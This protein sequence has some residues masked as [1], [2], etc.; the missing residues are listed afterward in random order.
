MVKTKKSA[1]PGVNIT[2][3][4]D[5]IPKGCSTPDFERKPIT[6]TLQEGKNAIFRAVV[7]GDP[8]PEILWQR[9]TGKIDDHERYRVSCVPGTNEYTLQISNITANDADVYR[10]TA[11][12]EYGEA[13]CSAGLKIIQVG[14]KKKPKDIAVAPQTDLKKEIK[15]F[16]KA[17][18]K[19]TPTAAPKKEIDMEQ[20]WQLLL[21][22]DRKDYE[23]ICLKY[24]IVD[25]R[26]MLRRLQEMKEE[27]E[28]KQAEYV[29]SI[30]NLKHVKI[31]E[32]QAN[33]SI[34]LEMELKNP[35]SR[36]YLY[37]DGEMINFGLNDDNIKH[38]LRQVGKK[39]NFVINDLQPEDAGV[40]QIK[41]EDVDI[42]S[43][44]LEA[45]NIPIYFR[46]PLGDV[47]CH[48]QGN[49]VLQCT[50][51]DPCFNAVWLHK[52]NR[53]EPNE[54]YEIS[55]S[56][57]GLMH[58]LVIKNAQ[59]SDKG[60]YTIDIG[61]RT[62]SAWLEVESAKGK[63]KQLEGD[64]ND[65]VGLRKKQLEDDH[66][67]KLRQGEA[68]DNQDH[69]A[70]SNM[71]KIG[72]YGTGQDGSLG[73][74]GKMGQLS[75]AGAD[76]AS[77][78]N[79]QTG[80]YGKDSMRDGAAVTGRPGSAGGADGL[81]GR[82]SMTG[83]ASEQRG[84][85]G[86]GGLYSKD[87][88]SDGAGGAGGIGGIY[89]KE[90]MFDSGGGPGGAVGLG[91]IY[92][93]DGVHIRAGGAGI[94][95]KDGMPGGT[96][97]AGYGGSGEAGGLY[98]KD[99]MLGGTGSAGVP[100]GIGGLYDKRGKPFGSGTGPDSN[101]GA[102]SLYGT[103]G[104]LGVAGVAGLY[105]KGGMPVGAGSSVP[106]G[107]G[108]A[109]GFYGRD[110]IL[111]GAGGSGGA[112]GVGG[113]GGIPVGTG[114]GGAGASGVIGGPYGKDGMLGG[115]GGAGGLEGLCDKDGK[116]GTAGLGGNGRAGGLGGLYGKGGMVDSSDR[117]GGTGGIGELYDKDGLPVGA[118]G[119]A[120]I[121]D[122]NGMITGV[123]P[124]GDA[125]AGGAGGFYGKD[126][127]L[128]STG[129]AGGPGGIGGFYGK[130]GMAVGT[131][132]SGLGGGRAVG[133]LY[134]KDGS[135]IG[136][137]GPGALGG[138]GGPHGAGGEGGRY[139]KDGM[140]VGSGTGRPGN[141]VGAESLYGKDGMPLKGGISAL[142]GAGGTGV[143]YGKDGEMGSAGSLH[144]KDHVLGG[145]SGVAGHIGG[146]YGIDGSGGPVGSGG[147][148][149]K[150]GTLGGGSD[151]EKLAGLYGKD[152]MPYGT[153]TAEHYGSGGRGGL[154]GKSGMGDAGEHP[155]SG[156]LGRHYGKD[157]T[158]AGAGT[159]GV[160][161][162]YGQDG[163][164]VEIGT[165]G[166][167]GAGGKGG[168]YGKDGMP[169]GAGMV[170]GLHGQDGMPF[171][172]GTGGH[173]GAGSKSGLYGKDGMPAGAGFAAPGGIG[174]VGGLYGQDGMPVGIGTGGP[175]SAGVKGGY[176][177]KDGMPAGA[178]TGGVGGLYGQDGMPVG[179]G[180]GGHGGAGGVGGLYGK[181]GMP[182]GAGMVG[183]LHGQD[184]MPFGIGTGGLA[185]AGGKGGLYGKDGMPAGAGTGGVGGLYGQDGMPVG[186]GTSGLAGA[187]D[188][189]GLYGKDG[190][191][192][193]AGFAAPGGIGGV[194]GLY[195][196]DGLPVGIGTGGPDGAGV[197]GGY[198]GKDGMPAGAGTGGVGGLY[199]QD[200]MPVGIGT[201]GHGGAGGVGGLYGKDG[202]PA[203]AGTGGVGGLYGQ[204]G[205]PVGLGT[206]GLA[207]AGG[208]GGLHGQDGMPAGAGLAGPGGIGGVRGL[209]GQDGM[210]VGI[211]TSG[212]AGAGGK[213]GLYG[214]DG[215]PAGAGT[216][217]V[218]GLYGKDG[219]PAGAGP[220]GPGGVGGVAGLYGPDGIPVG[221]GGLA[222]AGGKGE[223][224]GQDG[225]P[226]GAGPAGPGGI[227]GVAGLYGPDGIPVGIGTAGLAGAG[228]KGGLYG[229]DG[230]P[231]G[232]GTGGVGGLYGQDGMPVGIG[233]GGLAGAGGKGGLYGKDGMLAGAG[234]A[235]P[236]GIGGVS[237]LYGPDGMPVG[238]GTTG[239]SGAVG[240]GSL[241]DKAGIQGGAGGSGGRGGGLCGQDG[242]PI[243]T[244][245][246]GFGTAGRGG[247]Y[248]QDG[249]PGVVGTQG[250]G[251]A[252]GLHGK[253][254]YL[255]SPG[256]PD[257]AGGVAALYGKDGVLG[258]AVGA[259]GAGGLYGKDGIL[260]G[261][262]GA[263]SAGGV[264][265]LHGKD[266]M[267]IVS[268][269]GGEG[270]LHG[271]S[272]LPGGEGR[273]G[274]GSIVDHGG[275]YGKDGRAD[276]IGA[277]G[278]GLSE[279]G[280]L[281]NLF[282]KEG[283]LGGIG[284]GLG[285]G[286][287]DGSL[288]EKMSGIPGEEFLA[289]GQSSG[290]YGAGY[291]PGD[292]RQKLS[293]LDASG[294]IS[295]DVSRSRDRKGR[296]LLEEDAREPHC[297]FTQGLFDIHAHKGKAAVLLC[298]LNNDQ[299][300]GN[301]FKDG[302]KITGSDGVS[303]EKEGPVHK[304]IIDEVQEKHAGKY[305]FEAEDIRTEA[306]IFVEDPPSIDSALLNKL[307]NEPI[308]VKAGK[309]TIVKIPFEGR[310]PIRATWLKDDGELLD[311][312][313]IS[314]DYSDDYTRLTISSTNRKDSGDYKVKLKNESGTTEATLKLIVI[315][316]PQPPTGP[317]VV[318]DSSTSGIT[319]Q[320]KPPKDDGGKPIKSYV[321]ERQQ[322]GRKTW[323]T[324]GETDG[325]T[326]V[327]TTNK[328]EQ[329]KSYYF[330][331][332][333][334][335]AEGT[336]EVLESDEVMAAAKVFPG[337]PAPP[338]IISASKGTVSLSWAA[339]HKTG[340]SRI[341]GYTVEK[342][343]KG[344]NTWAPVTD[345][346]ITGK[347]YTVTD[348]K[349]GLQ[350]EFRVA[351]INAAGTGEAS[352]PSEAVFARDPMKP[353]GPVRDLKVVNTD[354]S[355]ISLSWL[356]PEAEE[357]SFAKGYIVE[358]RHSDTLK[359][360]P[361]NAVPITMTAYIVR[362]LKA[363][364]M[365]F[366]RVRAINDGG[367]GEAVELDT[368]VQAA[369]PS[370]GPKVLVKDSIKSFM[371]VKAGNTIRIRIPF[372]A[373]P[374]PEVFWQKD[375]KALPAK[376]TTTTRE[377]LSQLIIPGADFSDSGH[378]AI[379]L[380]T[381]TGKKETF[382]FLVQ[383]LDV[384][385][386]P[387]PIELVEKV[388]DTVTLIWEP[389][390]TEKR[391]RT[392]NYLVMRRDSY[393]GSWE[394][395]TD[396]IYTNK[397]TVANFVPGR[398][399]FFRVLAKN[400]MGISEPS[401]TV[402]PWSIHRERGKYEVRL[403]R[404]KGINHHQPPRFLVPLK[405]HVVILGFDCHMSCAVTGNP[406]PKVTWYKDGKNITK[407]PA[408]F[409]KNDFG[410]CSLM[411]PG[412]TP[413]DAGQYMAMA[414]NE[415]GE[416]NSKAELTI[417]E[418]TVW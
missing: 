330:R 291:H 94:Y 3:F 108:R 1:L 37:K 340:N 166:L 161:G 209:Y 323:L 50:L 311:D 39:Y 366:L 200:G 196:Q 407:D 231:A 28:T 44:E 105:G 290:F 174:G 387:G 258:G 82:Y 165:S 334:V 171:G 337:P 17:L 78:S 21:D 146:L 377:S 386:S 264:G 376:A 192:A 277:G 110:D 53:L 12:N 124:G 180:T 298:R 170:G 362:G 216:G 358:M 411:I 378:Y 187:G 205:M 398:E 406:A 229:K 68:H 301:W 76:M 73:K 75:G 252:G 325:N 190:M 389:S 208:K 176:Y 51:Y 339:P 241:F 350:Y 357:E 375:G 266:G 137:A 35:Q 197:K 93:K 40:Y 308:V 4:V 292:R 47:R 410:I 242:F 31:N 158:P 324:L 400:Y 102:G 404:Y 276:G 27:Q 150:D 133:S 399:Y 163:M 307:K 173:A 247:L 304:L 183:G 315:D 193:G 217:G 268:G 206:G 67:K 111:G 300:E 306:S 397:C 157:G 9:S 127:M 104:M 38:C 320:W 59:P 246:H 405:P 125:D 116:P 313:R 115:A 117:P 181:D 211:G 87:S 178:G 380:R 26:G 401:E 56:N 79:R 351:A 243:G 58:R 179:I 71:G 343:K 24:G 328:V 230:M 185:G 396:L 141:A 237:G 84:A 120:R 262:S 322:V 131:D 299:I 54:K 204:D 248:G 295:A 218:G 360:T 92:G 238:T 336:S 2:Q 207:G 317:I 302:L 22:A 23:K 275:L 153:G 285:A 15:H 99:G 95:G 64:S 214:K 349:E 194:G 256:G 83:D 332:R 74:D 391:D 227:G 361:C 25:F 8:R 128:V 10:F 215:V 151:A 382:G 90:G 305:K 89:E 61:R 392:L 32:Q 195:G 412:V 346:P 145:T 353:P 86:L 164:P 309:S 395:V 316:K 65:K 282:G 342:C 129:G 11:V 169:A 77:V 60:T 402:Q 232:A 257:D 130:E 244:S 321:I 63:R 210:P 126:G 255:G 103:D 240:E 390:P 198:Y 383:V 284:I 310:K 149:G 5:T 162:L 113:K 88:V 107:A 271:R 267:P 202:M 263:R 177:G 414:I 34:D 388:P 283:R 287:I 363:R 182:A 114:V 278:F 319:I 413:S 224:H 394:L 188:K 260:D 355:S 335:N 409:S 156:G 186:I 52:N 345:V 175:D 385:E 379:V 7:K 225:M 273:I 168:L 245:T 372:E 154:H 106:G 279:G 314:T 286:D 312:A 18:K 269:I 16:R 221:T 265:G 96:G 239:H 122:K 403:P 326:T 297:R 19:T 159:G 348:L 45:E 139:G 203:G 259:G 250:A 381:E 368:C 228:G 408:F 201:G 384:P 416:A 36:I 43:T 13:T 62:S 281:G 91:G 20:V 118:G 172:I 148:Y 72:Q 226:A 249:M 234:P 253:A 49:A 261:A 270:D 296:I 160:G 222:G 140:P 364:E 272:G 418:P 14:F 212:L 344:S 369:P 101:E 112:R 235:G 371:I 100:G 143:L 6:L 370:V 119:V 199:G 184:G 70:D 46:F 135:L 66:S 132:A 97:V 293:D 338:K 30:A 303:I 109:D 365:Y 223:L 85:G 274:P 289:Y 280:G 144:G 121:Y 333:A 48:E 57:D 374:S 254:G 123:G 55:V 341:L 142:S 167:A 393:K 189:G 138:A 33:A 356:K 213:G 81:Y 152:G 347:K 42:F 288:L 219:M 327:F 417:K 318:V 191:P 294:R 352:A 136:A 415:L 354:Y 251:R 359:W 147:P 41:V 233:T 29:H 155:G 80:L 98:G 331:V 69:S 373:S 329:D 367:L 236:S 220:A 134:G